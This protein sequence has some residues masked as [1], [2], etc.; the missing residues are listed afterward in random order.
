MKKETISYSQE[1]VT[2]SIDDVK[3]LLPDDTFEYQMYRDYSDVISKDMFKDYMPNEK[4]YKNEDGIIN[5]HN[6]VQDWRMNLEERIWELNIDWITDELDRE[7]RN[8]VKEALKEKWFLYDEL[9][10]DFCVGELYSIDLDFDFV[11]ERSPI[12]WNLVR[13]NNFDWF[14]EWETYEDW[15]AIKQFIDLFPEMVK[16]EDLENACNEWI[17]DGSDLKVSFRHSMKDFL[18]IIGN[19]EKVDAGWY[20]VLHLWVNGSWSPEFPIVWFVDMTKTY[21]TAFDK[22]DWE[23]DWR[24]GITEVYGSVLNN[25]Y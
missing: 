8:K 6:F 3:E 2:L 11:L 1:R 17:Y 23:F 22:W 16:K 10:F 15:Q 25:R 4:D 7:L 20:A 12:D 14:A 21:W 18:E 24:Y 5:Y 13:R 19:W 9:E